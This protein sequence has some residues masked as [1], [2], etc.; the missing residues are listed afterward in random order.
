MS[1][2]TWGWSNQV[3]LSQAENAE[4]KRKKFFEQQAQLDKRRKKMKVFILIVEEFFKK[5][6]FMDEIG[7]LVKQWEKQ[8]YNKEVSLADIQIRGLLKKANASEEFM[9][10][11]NVRYNDFIDHYEEVN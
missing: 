8:K 1:R 7:L 2:Y 5:S 6:L 4:K 11:W 9:N 3:A 10:E